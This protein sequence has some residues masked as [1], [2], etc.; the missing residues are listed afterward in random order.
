MS[1]TTRRSAASPAMT[2]DAWPAVWIARYRK[3]LKLRPNQPLV[4]DRDHVIAFLRSLVQRNKPAWQRLQALEAIRAQISAQGHDIRHLDDVQ[5]TL[6]RRVQTE[7]SALAAANDL[8]PGEPGPVDPNEPWVAQQL[9][10]EL[11]TRH[12]SLSTELAYVNWVQRFSAR[13]G[14]ASE[15]DWKVVASVQVR[16]FLT[17][18]AVQGNVAASTQNQAFS[19]LLFVFKHILKRPLDAKDVVRA[20]RPERLP[21]VLS[22]DEI[23]QVF[24]RLHGTDLLIAR[25]LYGAGLRI[26]ECLRLRV[27]DVDFG[28]QH[29]LVRDGKGQKDRVTLLPALV[30]DELQQRIEYRQRQ[31]QADLAAGTGRVFLPFALA[32]KWPN[33]D[34]EFGWQYIFA[35]QRLSRDPRSGT[36]RRHH[37]HKD[38]LQARF[39]AAVTAA[40]IAKPATPHTLR[41]SFATHLLEAGVDI[42]TIQQLLGH[43][44]VATTMVYTHVSRRGVTGVQSP[45]DRLHQSSAIRR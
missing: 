28:M 32:R 10:A 11:R 36:F 39:K 9:R 4:A 25:M 33:A 34:R 26:K 23:E 40:G 37:V 35:A 20:K 44:D 43:K 31:H 22:Q 2:R 21:L 16:T 27:K 41:H 17:E 13:W 19:A 8:P 38:A 29:I 42:R 6:Q 45:L 18:L 12:L 7:H 3:F 15:Q 24:A 30:H 5:T 14:V 1:T